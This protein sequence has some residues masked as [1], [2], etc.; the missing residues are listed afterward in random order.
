MDGR[1]SCPMCRSTD[2]RFEYDHEMAAYMATHNLRP[3]LSRF[4]RE[5]LKLQFFFMKAVSILRDDEITYLPCLLDD[6]EFNVIFDRTLPLP[7]PN[8]P[9]LTADTIRE[10]DS[11]VDAND[12]ASADEYLD[13]LVPNPNYV[14]NEGPENISRRWDGM[15]RLMQKVPIDI[16]RG[17]KR[18]LR[19]ADPYCQRLLEEVVPNYQN[20]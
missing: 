10:L 4:E 3:A 19:F 8:E 5:K 20:W 15:R 1:L 16:L 6:N 12:D 7:P 18:R 14:P 11:M 17:D 9:A 13:Y 2:Y